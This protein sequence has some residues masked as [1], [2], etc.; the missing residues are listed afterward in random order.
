MIIFVGVVLLLLAALVLISAL[1]PDPG[2]DNRTLPAI[3]IFL[4]VLGVLVI[5]AGVV[6]L[7]HR[8]P[9]FDPDANPR[10]PLW[11]FGRF[12]YQDVL[13]LLFP[14]AGAALIL[15][16]VLLPSAVANLPQQAGEVTVTACGYFEEAERDDYKCAGV[17]DPAEG[18]VVTLPPHL[19][20][21]NGELPAPGERTPASMLS[22][23]DIL[24]G[25]PGLEG[26]MLA[27]GLVLGGV[28]VPILVIYARNISRFVALRRRYPGVDVI[29][30][31]G[32]RIAGGSPGGGGWLRARATQNMGFMGLLLG[33]TTIGLLVTVGVIALDRFAPNREAASVTVA[34]CVD[35]G[36]LSAP[37]FRPLVT[38]TATASDGSLVEFHP[39]A[40]HY[41]PEG[42]VV[43]GDLVDGAFVDRS[44]G[45][46]AHP[47]IPVLA[48]LAGFWVLLAL[49]FWANLH[50]LKRLKPANPP[51]EGALAP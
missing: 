2:E 6:V 1:D 20:T 41:L 19:W 27:L 18:N 47:L 13:M 28:G 46:G 39:E 37:G 44:A 25:T 10:V 30:R 33:L 38:C 9:P 5:A 35:S 23:G 50:E 8:P 14:V 36:D 7:R 11:V 45:A 34:R 22:N 51:V 21:G 49:V 48:V 15:A 32:W 40:R 43:S 29:D 16:S 12:G 17:F 42:S 24:V 3:I 31:N 26:G 4:G